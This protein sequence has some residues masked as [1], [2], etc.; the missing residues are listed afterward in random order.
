MYLLWDLINAWCPVATMAFHTEWFQCGELQIGIYC[1]LPLIPTWCSGKES[2]CQCRRHKR[3]R[4][5]PWVG[6]IPWKRAWRPTPAFLPGKFHG[7]RSLTGYSPRGRRVR[8]DW[9]CVHS[10]TS[11]ST[12]IKSCAAAA[13]DIQHRLNGVQG[14][15]QKWGTLGKTGRTGLQTDIFRSRSYEPDS[16]ISSY[17]EKH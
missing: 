6:K 9:A 16:C 8:H 13:A 1:L 4:F 15:G 10:R 14:G 17:L 7:Q 2:A 3:L 5:D 12:R 11:T